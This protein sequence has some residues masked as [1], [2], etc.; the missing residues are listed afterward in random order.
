MLDG[1][2]DKSSGIKASGISRI[3]SI[4]V[5]KTPESYQNGAAMT[6]RADEFIPV[7]R[8]APP[9][10]GAA[11]LIVAAYGIFVVIGVRLIRT[12]FAMPA[13]SELSLPRSVFTIAN[14]ASLTGFQQTIPIDSYNRFGQAVL[15]ALIVS[16][17]LTSMIVG[18]AALV[19]ITRLPYSMKQICLGALFVEALAVVVGAAGL[20]R[21][22]R[23]LFE[24]L[25]QAAS[26]FGNCGVVVGP[27][28]GASDPVTSL[29]VLPLAV[30]GGLGLPV[31]MELFDC[32][33]GQRRLSTHART[34]LVATAVVYILGTVTLVGLQWPIKVPAGSSLL[35]ELR[36][37]LLTSSTIALNSRSLG[38]PIES[39]ALWPRNLSWMVLILMLIGAS[40]A[41]TG[42][43]IKTT[44]IVELARGAWGALRRRLVSRVFGI[45]LCWIAAYLL[46]IL[47]T[48]MRLVATEAQIPSDQVLFIAISAVGN[49]GSSLMPISITGDGLYV[50]SAAMMLGRVLPLIV[51][52]SAALSTQDADVA[53]G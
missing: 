32:V 35:N 12:S 42:G 52:W 1:S 13:G 14:A 3:Q 33:S 30:I 37:P 25:F 24:S 19:R 18:G 4:K 2:S 6:S 11:L 38:W 22:H 7:A 31:L 44:A 43:G 16:G 26:A 48:T 21:G 20:V 47:L 5:G 29:L 53:V 34:V 39:P 51:L 10:V 9:G 45:T 46:L 28:S 15:F 23:G 8:P 36:Q 27:V 17:S 40:P 50:L 41:G 49:V